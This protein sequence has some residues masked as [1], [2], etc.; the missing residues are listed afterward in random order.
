M[1]GCRQ[2]NFSEV[3]LKDDFSALDTGLFSAHVEEYFV[4]NPNVTEG[5]VYDGWGRKVLQFP[6]DGHPDMCNAVLDLTGDCRD[7][8]ASSGFPGLQ[9]NCRQ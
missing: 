6:D 8:E 2:N 5:G 3:L 4:H 1:L 9:C 7:E